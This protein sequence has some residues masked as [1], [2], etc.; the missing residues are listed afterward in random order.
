MS[1]R[2]QS[3]TCNLLTS[4][5]VHRDT[6]IHASTTFLL[7]INLRVTNEHVIL[8]QYIIPLVV[9]TSA[10]PPA[11]VIAIPDIPSAAFCFLEQRLESFCFSH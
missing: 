11:C 9:F 2:G 5:A 3:H 8:K 7:K 1:H 6:K 10:S 4:S